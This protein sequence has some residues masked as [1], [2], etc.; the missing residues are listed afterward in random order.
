MLEIS[1]LRSRKHQADIF[2]LVQI[3]ARIFLDPIVF[4]RTNLFSKYQVAPVR[5]F[6]SKVL[7]L[8]R[9][10]LLLLRRNST[11]GS[12]ANDE[13]KIVVFFR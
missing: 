5:P 11:G 9:L 10:I 1:S 3:L 7:K 6:S 8:Q 13:C 12:L 4:W 2:I